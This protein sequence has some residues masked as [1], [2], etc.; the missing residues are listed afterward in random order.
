MAPLDRKGE[1][2][3][4]ILVGGSSSQQVQRGI[5]YAT[6]ALPLLRPGDDVAVLPYE[7]ATR[8]Y[9]EFVREILGL[10][11]NQFIWASEQTTLNSLSVGDLTPTVTEEIKAWSTKCRQKGSKSVVVPYATSA[12]FEAWMEGLRALGCD[13]EPVAGARPDDKRAHKGSLHRSVKDLD[14]PSFVEHLGDD[15]PVP[16]GFACEDND[17]LLVAMALL[18]GSEAVVKPCEGRAGEGVL[19]VSSAEEL[20]LYDFPLGPVVLQERLALDK[21]LDGIELSS[22]AAKA[23]GDSLPG[24]ERVTIGPAHFGIKSNASTEA[25]QAA[26]GAW[27]TRLL[28][29]HPTATAEFV[30]VGGHPLLMSMQIGKLQADHFVMAFHDRYAPGTEFYVWSATPPRHLDVWV[31]WARLVE[32][33]AAFVPPPAGTVPEV[34]A[35]CGVFP[36][37]YLKGQTA[38]F[39]AIGPTQETVLRLKAVA[40]EAL[41][42]DL[43]EAPLKLVSWRDDVRRIWV[44]GPRP[45]YRRIT[46]RFNMPNRCLPLV[47]KG[48]DFIVIP[49]GHDPTMEFAEF[50]KEVCELDEDQVIVT[51]GREYNLDDDIS[52]DPGVIS[53]LKAIVISNP[54]DKFTL[55]PYAV[56]PNFERWANQFHELGVTVFGESL[57]WILKFG[58]KGILHRRV[59]TPDVPSIVEQIGA[60]VPVARG[61]HCC[62]RDEL[63]WAWEWLNAHGVRKG[64]IKP[65]LGAAGEGIIFVTEREQLAMYDFPM[66]DVC[67]EEFLNLDCAPDGVVLSPAVHYMEGML[68]GRGLVDQIMIGTGYAGWRESAVPKT[69]QVAA[70]GC[71]DKLIRKMSPKGPGGFDFLSV[72]GTP[73]LSDVNTGRF[74][75]AHSP[76]IFLDLYSKG[77][78]FYCWKLKPPINADLWLYWKGLTQA[79]IAFYPGRSTRGVFPLIFLRGLSGQFIAIAETAEEAEKLRYEADRCLADAVSRKPTLKSNLSVFKKADI[80]HRPWRRL[81]ILR[82]SM[83]SNRES[84][85]AHS[86]PLYAAALLRPGDAIV[87]PDREPTRE[88]WDFIRGLLHL[89]D[90]QAYFASGEDLG[91]DLVHELVRM[92]IEEGPAPGEVSRAQLL[93]LPLPAAQEVAPETVPAAEPEPVAPLA[94]KSI[95]SSGPKDA[96]LTPVATAPAT[97]AQGQPH[98]SGLRISSSHASIGEG[99]GHSD[100][101]AVTAAATETELREV[102]PHRRINRG[103]FSLVPF[104][105]TAAFLQWATPLLAHGVRVFGDDADWLDKYSTHASM[106]PTVPL[107]GMPIEAA[108]PTSLG[109]LNLGV[110][111][112]RGFTCYNNIELVRAWDLLE[113]APCVV[114]PA[115]LLVSQSEG[116]LSIHSEAEL[117]LYDFPHGPAVLEEV[118]AFDRAADGIP[119]SISVPFIKNDVIGQNPLDLL[120]VGKHLVGVRT[121]TLDDA[122]QEELVAIVRKMLR[123]LKPKGAG[124][125]V[126]GFVNGEPVLKSLVAGRFSREHFVQLFVEAHAEDENRAFVGWQHRVPEALDVWT[127]WSRLVEKG[128]AFVPGQSASGVFPLVFYRGSLSIFLAIGEDMAEVQRLRELADELLRA[129]ARPLRKALAYTRTLENRRRIFA[130]SPLPEHRV[131]P[132]S[133]FVI[134]C[135]SLSLLRPGIDVAIVPGTDAVREYAALVAEALGITDQQ[136]VYTSNTSAVMDDDVDDDT[137]VRIKGALLGTNTPADA[138]APPPP[139]GAAIIPFEASKSFRRWSSQLGEFHVQTYAEEPPNA[140]ARTQG[141]WGT[142]A[143]MHRRARTPDAP[144]PLELAAKAK[145]I[146]V[147]TPHGYVCSNV[148]E[149]V[150]AFDLLRA[151][152]EKRQKE[153]SAAE[154]AKHSYGFAAQSQAASEPEQFQAVLKP[155]VGI[156]GEHVLTITDSEQLRL[157]AFSAGEVVLEE[158]LQLDRASDDLQ[159]TLMVPFENGKVLAN[160]I[161][162][163]VVVGN[164]VAGLRP[165]MAPRKLAAKAAELAGVLVAAAAPATAGALHF[166]IVNGAP[167]LSGMSSSAFAPLLAAM[168]FVRQCAPAGSKYFMWRFTPPASVT[169]QRFYSTLEQKG[170][171]FQPG[172]RTRGIFPALYLKGVECVCVAISSTAL[173]CALLHDKAIKIQEHLVKEAARLEAGVTEL[174]PLPAPAI[175]D[176]VAADLMLI[177]NAEM[178]YSPEPLDARNILVAGGKVVAL[179]GEE[180]AAVMQAMAMVKVLDA[181]GAIVVP[182][183]VDMHVHVTGGGGEAGPS[184]R[185]PEAKLSELLSGGITT[186]VGILGTDGFSRSQENLLAKCRALNEEGMTAYM[187]SG[188]YACPGPTLT[189][190]VTKDIM[191]VE[192]VIGVGE[193]AVSDHRGSQ[194]TIDTLA[195][196]AAEARV[197]GMLSNKAGIVHIHIGPGKGLLKPLWD[198]VENSEIPITQFIPTHMD[199]SEELIE[200]G[201][202]WLRAGGFLDFTGRSVR[203]RVALGKYFHEGLPMENVSVSSDSYGS[204]PTFDVNGKL[205]AYKAADTKALLRLLR[206]LYFQM[207]WPIERIIPLMTSNPARM[208]KLRSKGRI[209]VGK[210]ADLLL[211]SHT[212]LKLTHV[213]ARGKLVKA[214]GWTQGGLF[215]KGKNI[216]PIL[217]QE[218]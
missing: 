137:I 59:A 121:S 7:S 184:S 138:A 188:N 26:V 205:V 48:I 34:G 31:Y 126:F 178:V 163:K 98:G 16:R 206:Q 73:I 61:W 72:N 91:E 46:Q 77:N 162:D 153:R 173:D 204:L 44:S 23:A 74:N 4:W 93:P 68:I 54:K 122:R 28:A 202:K 214:P 130:L 55:V 168:H 155:A 2:L 193:V 58:H 50:I 118:L 209:D 60:T 8:E 135:L 211:L 24:F 195:G 208:L 185:T 161:M 21:T 215:E 108:Q 14:S 71:I 79:G 40:D 109:K 41:R 199:R 169:A 142:R 85:F 157:Y 45:E 125:A 106:Y 201:A 212:T 12:P 175:P 18:G 63:L 107:P 170:V 37:S 164:Y 114:K 116:V 19:V 141:A 186:V 144:S 134:P 136:I 156:L 69:F 42:A 210:D 5:E 171:A 86:L 167:V 22:C 216:R 190:S 160:E 191:S 179:L 53:R 183:I 10:S 133:E 102:V 49:G 43:E 70:V 36:V 143:W 30:S 180:E 39:I 17:D 3:A 139:M 96:K 51:S 80:L 176:E 152:S 120:S 89:E 203:T 97:L 200:D 192:Q 88:Y 194:P 1:A 65:N 38:T 149:L 197:A 20:R 113:R 140:A 87:L 67:L 177:R 159:L 132:C 218:D 33:K 83:V 158:H 99:H 182:G 172:S 47:R 105:P 187:W 131:W 84:S 32:Q 150:K 123:A 166:F 196:L 147:E 52:S 103:G 165:T 92:V 110:K 29:D 198:V 9:A 127:F 145:G 78:S 100:A 112:L 111:M 189:G 25:H 95:A 15:I 94:R 119:L 35:G 181:A 148:D 82:P 104:S 213:V 151:A 101:I 27:S 129:P 217:P 117:R 62:N 13:A 154:E 90:N 56:T 57:E 207:R 124:T 66:G 75:G 146:T 6:A 76:K 64:V 128:A 115:A 11:K 174:G 81:W